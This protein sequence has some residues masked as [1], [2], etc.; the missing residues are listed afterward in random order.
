MPPDCAKIDD[1]N[2]YGDRDD[3]INAAKEELRLK[4]AEIGDT[5]SLHFKVGITGVTLN[6]YKCF[7]CLY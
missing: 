1:D 5:V 7:T 3:E 2:L 6:C 4:T